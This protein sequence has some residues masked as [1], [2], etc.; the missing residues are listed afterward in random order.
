MKIFILGGTGF[1]GKHLCAGLVADG[2]EVIASGRSTDGC[3]PDIPGVRW[4]KGDFT[5]PHDLRPVLEGVEV[6]VHLVSTS[7]PN[8]SN[9]NPLLDL[10]ENVGSTLLL[11][12]TLVGCPFPP[13]MIFVS[14]G[15]TVYGIPQSVP[16]AE[17]HPTNPLCAYG[18]GKLAIEKYLALYNRLYNIEYRIIRLANPYGEGQ[19][20]HSGQG[21]I[22]V[23]LN[24]ALHEEPLKIWGDGSVVR[25]YLYVG[26]VI[27]AI[28]SLLTFDGP[29]RIFNVG[30]GVG[31][32]LNDLVELIGEMLGR[33]I[34]CRYLPGRPCDV[35]INVLDITRATARLEWAP[36]TS[37]KEGMLKTIRH[38]QSC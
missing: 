2:H 24:H 14:S 25:D 27:N 33:K 13:C 17:T 26:D 4:V 38:L 15:G 30:S 28:T 16:I 1:I 19:P 37:L 7:L 22:P 35:P 6:V 5:S 9:E 23:F 10:Q 34:V 21:V 12:D 29:E 32:S 18:I 8:D 20:L 3:W 36:S 11:L 31:H